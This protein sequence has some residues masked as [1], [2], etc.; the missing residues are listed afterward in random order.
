MKKIIET[1]KYGVIKFKESILTGKKR[2]TIDGV[3]LKKGEEDFYYGNINGDYSICK[4]ESSVFKG[5]K[6]EVNREEFVITGMMKWY[7]Y[8]LVLLPFIVIITWGNCPRLCSFVPII[9]GFIGGVLSFICSLITLV[10]IRRSNSLV[11]KIVFSLI[12]LSFSL[13][14]CSLIVGYLA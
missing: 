9:G 8:I 2:I 12:M 13:F 7:E 3:Q 1:E 6:I 14:I 4:V 5:V 10:Y 11:F